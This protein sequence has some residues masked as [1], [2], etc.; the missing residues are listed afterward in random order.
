MRQKLE[1]LHRKSDRILEEILR[2]HKEGKVTT[3]TSRGEEKEDLIDVLL[4]FQRDGD[5]EFQLTDSNIKAVIWVSILYL[6]SN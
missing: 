5:F 3:N 1:K 4:N 6:V 2:E